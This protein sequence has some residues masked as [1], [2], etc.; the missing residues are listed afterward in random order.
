MLSGVALLVLTPI[1]WWIIPRG[2]QFSLAA[3]LLFSF[4]QGS[5]NLAWGIGAGRLLFVSI[6][7]P[8]K[9]MDYMAVYFAWVGIV[10]GISQV[11]GGV[12]LDLARGLAG[13][14]Y[15]LEVDQYTPLFV[16][17]ILLPAS[18]ILIFRWVRG[19]SAFSTVQFAGIFLRGNPFLAVGSVISFHRARGEYDAVRAT[20]RMGVTKSPLTVDELLDAL[21]DPRFNVRFEAIISMARMPADNRLVDALTAVLA[22]K[23]PALA[24]VAAWALGRMGDMRSRPALRAGLESPY[25]S[26]RAHC[27]RALGTLGDTEI[28]ELLLERMQ[29]E[30]DEGLRVAYA[31]AL[32][33]LA[34]EESVRPM[35]T[36]L[37]DCT[38]ESTR[39]EVA[40]AL[41]RIVGGEH[42][43]IQLVRQARRQPGTAA[44]QHLDTVLRR[45]AKQRIIEPENKAAL[46]RCIN[47]FA[48]EEVDDAT[49]VLSEWILTM[50]LD[51]YTPVCREILAECALR[52]ERRGTSRVEYVLLALHALHEGIQSFGTPLRSGPNAEQSSDIDTQR[53][54]LA[55]PRE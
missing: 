33:K 29:Q 49:A 50:P 3:A 47:L 48:R 17:A 11:G 31:Y 18:S 19:D 26:I 43:Y 44:A 24:V 12:I 8:S 45:L 9:K 15:T 52:L 51:S 38:D 55:P 42:T 4:T 1:L 5:A 30:P 32:G 6:V 53:A 41:A 23:S 36:L 35:L 34:V 13:T 39:S 14:W 40:L 2:H 28:A 27:V 16:I 37:R 22:G 46:Q 25:R 54:S 21:A 20:E 10:A 7:P